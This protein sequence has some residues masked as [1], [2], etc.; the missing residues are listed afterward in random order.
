MT[1]L[2]V[3]HGHVADM[4]NCV[5]EISQDDMKYIIWEIAKQDL[6]K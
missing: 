3:C 2:T 6:V 1:H 4:W 5:A